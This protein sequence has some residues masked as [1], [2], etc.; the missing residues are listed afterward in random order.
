M[1]PLS[2]TP[3][4]EG[5]NEAIFTAADSNVLQY[6]LNDEQSSSKVLNVMI[7]ARISADMPWVL[8]KSLVGSPLGFIAR[9]DIPEGV[10]VSVVTNAS[11]ITAALL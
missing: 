2:F 4:A 1:T 11:S 10:T 3:N 9:L 8:I 5:L 6:Q 7:R